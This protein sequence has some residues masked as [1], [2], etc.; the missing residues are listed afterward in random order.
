[1]LGTGDKDHIIT[2]VLPGTDPLQEYDEDDPADIIMIDYKTDDSDDMDDLSEVSMTSAGGISKSEFQ[3]LLADIM[4]QHQKMAASIDALAAQVGD[5]TV[6]QVEEADVRVTSEIG[7]IRGMD[8]ITGVFDKAKIGLILAKGVRKF[9]K[10][11][12]LKVKRDEKDIV[13]YRQLEKKFCMNKRTV[14]ECA[15]G[16]NHQYPKGVSTKVPFTLTKPEDEEEAQSATK[17]MSENAATLT[18]AT[19]TAAESVSPTTNTT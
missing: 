5:M 17:P 6:E 3:G 12:S 8:E 10:Y 9:H 16:F 14:M 19:S 18:P 15:Q 1:M 13:S 11:Q 2:K 7:H 4:A